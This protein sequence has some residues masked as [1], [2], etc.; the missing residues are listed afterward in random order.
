V[1]PRAIHFLVGMLV[2][3]HAGAFC[4]CQLQRAAVSTGISKA[5]A[6]PFAAR[7]VRTA[8]HFEASSHRNVGDDVGDEIR[9]HVAACPGIQTTPASGAVVQI[10]LPVNAADLL[11]APLVDPRHGHHLLTRISPEA[12]PADTLSLPL[13]I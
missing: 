6:V 7:I 10:F 9:D 4:A 8:G 5:P 2:I 1:R 3:V 11:T 13:L 12:A